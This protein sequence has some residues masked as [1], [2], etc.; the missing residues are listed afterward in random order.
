[1]IFGAIAGAING[2][3]KAKAK[4]SY[5]QRFKELWATINTVAAE[6]AKG[7]YSLSQ[8]IV[9]L[10][11]MQS[12]AQECEYIARA[13]LKKPDLLRQV[14]ALQADLERGSGLITGLQVGAAL[15]PPI[16]GVN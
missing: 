15:Q 11:E 5:A 10:R 9:A 13:V 7:K 16:A 1:M 14:N 12:M 2:Y 4:Q 6:M 3:R 8:Q